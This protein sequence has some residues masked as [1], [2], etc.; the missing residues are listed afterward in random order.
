[1]LLA[2]TTF[3]FVKPI[4]ISSEIDT[5]L[6]HKVIKK[7]TR[8]V[9]RRQPFVIL[10]ISSSGG[11]CYAAMEIMDM[12]RSVSAHLKVVTVVKSYAASAAALI[13]AC[14]TP[15]YR[16]MAQHA[17]LLFHSVQVEIDRMNVKEF[18]EE[19]EEVQNLNESM[20]TIAS[21]NCKTDNTLHS[22]IEEHGV[23]R[24]MYTRDCLEHQIADHPYVPTV[25]LRTEATLNVK[26]E[27]EERC[28]RDGLQEIRVNIARKRRRRKKKTGR[29]RLQ[30]IRRLHRMT[31]NPVFSV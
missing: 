26:S 12:I 3:D 27:T 18:T 4:Q 6:A 13:F 9:N 22:L 16:F 15:G 11:E 30:A 7:L 25:T 23:D 19:F 29:H 17:R 21:A 2:N 24:Y 14:G 20:C 28:L 10:D 8:A 5:D 1:M 31:K